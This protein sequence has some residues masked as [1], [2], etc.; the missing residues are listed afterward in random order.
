[1]ISALAVIHIFV[2]AQVPGLFSLHRIKDNLIHSL[3]P[4]SMTL[5]Q[6]VSSVQVIDYFDKLPHSNVLDLVEKKTDQ[7]IREDNGHLYLP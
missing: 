4:T 3:D 5:L 7:F 2:S 1:M 6:A